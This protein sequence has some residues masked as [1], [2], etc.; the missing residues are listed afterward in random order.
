[1]PDNAAPAGGAA[2]A[3]QPTQ[4]QTRTYELFQKL[5]NDDKLGAQVRAKAKE[6]YPDITLPDEQFAPVIAPLKAQIDELT[7][8]LAAEREERSKK[9]A[10]AAEAAAAKTFEERAQAARNG[11][12]LTPDGFDK[13]IERMKETGNY[14]DF[15]AAAA[16]VAG[17]MPKPIQPGPYLGPQSL[18]L[19]GSKNKDEQYAT[20]WRDPSGSFLDQEFTAFMDNPRQYIQEAGFDPDR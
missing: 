9:E 20:L 11:Y 5:W 8:T 18:D 2:P 1:M 19:F 14:T 16:W 12:S 13:M 3:P 6:V 17:Q 10:E 7:A 4:N 15:E